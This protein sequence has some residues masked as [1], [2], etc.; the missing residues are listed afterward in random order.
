MAALL[1]LLS[2]CASTRAVGEPPGEPASP[3]AVVDPAPSPPIGPPP[4]YVKPENYWVREKIIL[5]S[6]PALPASAT[7]KSSVKKGK[8]AKKTG[9]RFPESVAE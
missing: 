5:T 7:P 1:T 4:G 6:E 9:E 8:K 2:G 3:P